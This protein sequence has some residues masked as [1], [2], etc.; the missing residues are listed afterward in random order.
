LHDALSK[1][2]PM[3]FGKSVEQNT[4]LIQ[5]ASFLVVLTSADADMS[6]SG[7]AKNFGYSHWHGGIMS[8]L[9]EETPSQKHNR[10]VGLWLF[11]VYLAMYAGFVG[12]TAADYKLMGLEVFGGINIAI[13]YGM[14]LIVMAFVLAIVYLLLATDDPSPVVGDDI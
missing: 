5:F 11:V 13:V 10:K 6:L 9:S 7:I 12:I 2:D 4:E 3:R 14:G 8:D 1:G